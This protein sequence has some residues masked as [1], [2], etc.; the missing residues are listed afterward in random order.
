MLVNVTFYSNENA[1][2]YVRATVTAT[3]QPLGKILSFLEASIAFEGKGRP[4]GFR[5]FRKTR[6]E[7]ILPRGSQDRD[8]RYPKGVPWDQI[9]FFEKFSLQKLF[10][11]M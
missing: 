5:R 10:G 1:W 4:S 2:S 8:P 6:L 7:N 3:T 9:F 11:D